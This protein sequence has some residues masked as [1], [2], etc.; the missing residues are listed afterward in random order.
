MVKEGDLVHIQWFTL[1]YIFFF[2]PVNR[3][4]GK[5]IRNKTFVKLFQ[6]HIL[7]E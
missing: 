2:R 5:M 1:E 6:L 4:R 7:S 3:G